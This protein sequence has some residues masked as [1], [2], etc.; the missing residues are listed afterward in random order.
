MKGHFTPPEPIHRTGRSAP[1]VLL[2][3]NRQVLL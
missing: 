2:I 3:S 1:N